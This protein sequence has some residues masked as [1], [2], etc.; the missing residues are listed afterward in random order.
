MRLCAP[1]WYTPEINRQ[2]W[3]RIQ[4][5]MAAYAYEVLNDPIMDDGEFDNLCLEVN[6]SIDTRRPDMDEW[7]RKEFSPST[8]S[9][10]YRHPE[11][12]KIEYLVNRRL[13][14]K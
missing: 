7:F 4:V 11:L 14:K 10:I 13:E 6:L 5:A 3:V 2:I 9:W 12:K 1:E 8:G